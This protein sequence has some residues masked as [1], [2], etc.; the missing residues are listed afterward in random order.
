MWLVVS[1]KMQLQGWRDPGASAPFS[2][3]SWPLP[4]SN[5]DFAPAGGKVAT[6][7]GLTFTPW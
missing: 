4:S 7:Q 2:A 3:P 5:G 1:R 6:V